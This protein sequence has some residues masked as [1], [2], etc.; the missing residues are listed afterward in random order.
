VFAAA[1]DRR[2]L[3]PV[4]LARRRLTAM[5][6]FSIPLA[7]ANVTD[8]A[9]GKWDNLLVSRYNGAGVAGAYNLA[10]N[11]STT[12]TG[13]PA[14]QILDVLFPSFTA[15]DPARRGPALVRAMSSMALLVMPLAF[16]LAAVATT[17]VGAL[18]PPRWGEIAPLLV[19]LSVQA[20]LVPLAS[21]LQAFCRAQSRTG[22][23]MLSSAIR[24]AILM[25]GLVAIGSWGP[26]WACAV[27]DV[28]ALGGL[29][30]V[31]MAVR[32]E[33]PSAFGPSVRGVVQAVIAC[34]P[35]GVAVVVLQG[36]EARLGPFPARWT[37]APEVLAGT[38]GYALGAYLF[39]RST[40]TD[41]IN[42]GRQMIGRGRTV[43]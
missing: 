37:L 27:V 19:V 39:A 1:A 41:V 9:A 25:G 42:L 40:A 36:V 4:R 31:G 14:D 12:S 35:M 30:L 34:V 10:F 7:L 43:A 13:A 29:V 6:R 20:A 32:S 3:K 2:W 16:G 38:A 24:L 8:F 26:R 28:S 15:I 5:L 21:T 11:L 22:V 23:V 33:L 17:V 18:F